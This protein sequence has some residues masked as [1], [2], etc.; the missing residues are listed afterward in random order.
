MKTDFNKLIPEL[1]DWNNGKG[2]DVQAWI[3]CV[4]SFQ[5][6]IGYSTMFWPEF[7][8]IEGCIVRA[9]VPE[10][11]V[12]RWLKQCDGNP[13]CAEA[14]I[15]HVH[16]DGLHHIGCEDM[17]PERVAYLGRVLREIYDCKL[18]RDFPDKRFVVTLDE[19][20]NKADVENY[21]LTFYQEEQNIE[22]VGTS[23]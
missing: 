3:E 8:E 10:E 2:I 18:R 15:N 23:P 1:K 6:A 11:N 20:D 19:P 4:G 14:T 13:R 12:R 16:L 9:G 22:R 21:I 17:S 7:V 5:K